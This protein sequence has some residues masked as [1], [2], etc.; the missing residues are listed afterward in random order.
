MVPAVLYQ[1]PALWWPPTVPSLKSSI[2]NSGRSGD[3]RVFDLKVRRTL[4]LFFSLRRR[5]QRCREQALL[6][7]TWIRRRLDRGGKWAK[8]GSRHIGRRAVSLEKSGCS[9]RP[10]S[11]DQDQ[12]PKY[13]SPIVG[14]GFSHTDGLHCRCMGLRYRT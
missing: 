11:H 13:N 4:S 8:K 2:L 12:L 7:M 5:Q 10:T 3:P 9:G 1:A 14:L 6:G